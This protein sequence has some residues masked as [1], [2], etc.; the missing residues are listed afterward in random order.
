M[1]RDLYR[2][3]ELWRQ[4]VSLQK[5]EYPKLLALSLTREEKT[6]IR[7]IPHRDIS[8]NSLL[9]FEKLYKLCDF[10]YLQEERYSWARLHY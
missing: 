5:A 7:Q 3:V 6:V 1:K 8:Q 4:A 2:E 9:R 10:L